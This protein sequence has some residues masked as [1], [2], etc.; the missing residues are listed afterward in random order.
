MPLNIYLLQSPIYTIR[1]P[2]NTTQISSNKQQLY[3]LQN[4]TI[5]RKHTTNEKKKI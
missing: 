1:H 2:K 4:Y 5:M 3:P